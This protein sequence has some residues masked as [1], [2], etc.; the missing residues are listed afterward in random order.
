MT[1]RRKTFYDNYDDDAF[2]TNLLGAQSEPGD[3]GEADIVDLCGDSNAAKGRALY[4]N[5]AVIQRSFDGAS[6]HATIL[7]GVNRL[8]VVFGM[9]DFVSTCSDARHMRPSRF[10]CEHIA[11]LLYAFAREPESFVPQSVGGLFDLLQQ[12]PVL[13]QQFGMS[14]PQFDALFQA[15][16]NAPPEARAALE[17]LPLNPTPQQLVAVMQSL[18]AIA[19]L[20]AAEQLK[21]YLRLLTPDQLRAIASHRGWQLASNAKEGMVAQLAARLEET[22]LPDAFTPEEEQL[23]RLQNTLYGI[24]T[25]PTQ[26]MLK[27]LWKKRAGGDMARLD[28]AVR[29]LEQAGVWFLCTLER[30][31]PHYHWSPFIDSADLPL[32]TPK[33][34]PYPSEKAEQLQPAEALPPLLTL[35]DAVVECAG[36]EPLNLHV[37]EPNAQFDTLPYIRGWNYDRQE[38]ENLLAPRMIH[39]GATNMLSVPF[40]FFFADDTL[41]TL[42]TF[43]G[44]SRDHAN[45]LAAMVYLLG[46]VKSVDQRTA[47]VDPAAITRWRALPPEE[48]Y[49]A[50]WEAWCVGAVSFGEL[51]LALTRASALLRRSI[52][53]PDF[54]TNDLIQEIGRARQFV[55]RLLAKLDPLVWYSWKSFAEYVRD[56]RAD[57]VHTLTNQQTWHLASKSNLQ[58]Q[59]HNQSHWDAAYR[60]LLATILEGGLHWLGAVE[61]GYEGKDLAAFQITAL[62]AWLLSG[63]KAG[64]ALTLAPE[65]VSG[66]AVTWIDDGTFRLRATPDVARLVPLARTFADPTRELFTFHISN[67]SI[68][69]A[70]ER[71]ITPAEIAEPFAATGA[72]LPPALRERL[73]ALQANYGRVHV[74]ERLTVL[75]LADD[76]AL[77]ELVAGTGMGK[78]I[79]HQFSPRLVVIQDEGVDELVNELVKKGYTPRVVESKT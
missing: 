16:Q 63:G 28:R 31:S 76:M 48:Q 19:P 62:G 73:D 20:Q 75:E 29:G 61:L 4:Q 65:V 14:G 21:V 68:A 44:T 60:P 35:A 10:R 47:S 74:Y 8:P 71:G 57:F 7:D 70:F 5:G 32:L 18:E 2:L 13:R 34:K 43:V 30:A 45:W 23:V 9:D 37:R 1:K 59:P 22:P 67:H 12:N 72:P 69:R 54:S 24:E 55:A 3:F 77:R 38:V 25:T 66:E 36:R 6:L 79:V 51:R 64:R 49:R 17:N 78:Y 26:N 46:L 40:T 42:T 11:A 27:S 53:V 15:L 39:W 33:V 58:Y 52:K 50:L 56:L 41:D